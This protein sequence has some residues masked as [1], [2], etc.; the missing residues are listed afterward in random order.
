METLLER[1][2]NISH[3]ELEELDV[4]GNYTRAEKAWQC[5]ITDN[6]FV[7]AKQRFKKFY[8]KITFPWRIRYIKD[9]N[10]HIAC[11]EKGE[12]VL[13]EF[14]DYDFVDR[15]ITVAKNLDIYC[16]LFPMGRG[17]LEGIKIE[18]KV[19]TLRICMDNYI[20]SKTMRIVS[21]SQSIHELYNI[22][23]N[24]KHGDKL[25]FEGFEFKKDADYILYE[26]M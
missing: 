2:E 21:H 10:M 15:R 20:S 25:A 1:L 26:R 13:Y 9:L 14:S 12:Y 18:K 17:W 6:H 3:L 8:Y 24:M 16:P 7:Y 4:S 22:L 5:P 11:I 19:I 23:S